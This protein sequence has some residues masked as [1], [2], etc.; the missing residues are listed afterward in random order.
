MLLPQLT[1]QQFLE[2][3]A[4]YR[5]NPFGAQREDQR[6]EAQR[7]RLLASIFGHG[8]S[9]VVP[10]AFYPYFP[11]VLSPDEQLQW[12]REVDAKLIALPDGR[13]VWKDD[14]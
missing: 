8:L 9:E 6:A 12:M 2:W 5:V 1:R 7:R 11:P 4:Y 13:H 10:E 3:L 14:A